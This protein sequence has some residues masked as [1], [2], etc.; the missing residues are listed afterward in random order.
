MGSGDTFGFYQYK[1]DDTKNY[2]VKLSAATAAQGTFTTVAD[3]LG[4]AGYPY[5][6]KNMR[7]VW[8]VD[9]AGKRAK[10]PM[11]D[12]T[13]AKF[14]AGGTFTLHGITYTIQGAIGEQRKLSFLGG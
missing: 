7:H 11:A 1:S 4:T 2:V 10:V 6:P 5:G 8:G 3:P 14:V 13:N 12:A 9:P